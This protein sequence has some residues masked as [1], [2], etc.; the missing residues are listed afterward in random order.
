MLRRQPLVGV[1]FEY[2]SEPRHYQPSSR[3]H[4]QFGVAQRVD[5]GVV[6]RIAEPVQRPHQQT[7]VETVHIAPNTS[8][9]GAVVLVL[10][11]Q[12]TKHETEAVRSG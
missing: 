7:L 11:A 4:T 10:K 6:A 3:L 2:G 5:V 8:V 1:V 12:R 9:P